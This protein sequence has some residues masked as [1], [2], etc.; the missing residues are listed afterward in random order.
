MEPRIA[1]IKYDLFP[2]VI[3]LK[4]LRW[5]DEGDAVGH[6]NLVYKHSSI[7]HTLP[8]EEGEAIA[9]AIEHTKAVHREREKELRARLLRDLHDIA[10]FLK[11]EGG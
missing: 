3:T 9:N 11:P 10:P 2:Y 4:I 5:N 8:L 1:F 7:I 6:G